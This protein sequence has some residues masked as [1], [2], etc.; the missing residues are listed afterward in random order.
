[1]SLAKPGAKAG[2]QDGLFF[3]GKA[4]SRGPG[5]LFLV[6]YQAQKIFIFVVARY[7]YE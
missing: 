4:I 6:E 7:S 1:M 2:F 3:E 5:L